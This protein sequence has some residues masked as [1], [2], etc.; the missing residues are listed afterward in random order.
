MTAIYYTIGM[1]YVAYYSANI[2]YDLLFKKGKEKK[3]DGAI[4][5]SLENLVEEKIEQIAIDD[6]ESLNV[7]NSYQD[8][9]KQ[10]QAES[11]PEAID[12]EELR[13]R[14]EAEESL[15]FLEKLTASIEPV[16]KLKTEK[17]HNNFISEV[18]VM[19]FLREAETQV[20]LVKNIDGFKTY[21]IKDL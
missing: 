4:E 5:I 13:H 8:I 18:D 11:K 10:V 15:D 7:P 19:N 21:A 1:S 12:L 9:S 2:V 16:P 14:F 3:E 20:Q 6:V 17:V